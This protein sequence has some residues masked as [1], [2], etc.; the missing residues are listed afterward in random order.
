[1]ESDL[2]GADLTEALL[3]GAKLTAANLAGANLTGAD[4]A[5]AAR[6]CRTRMPDES[7]CDRDCDPEEFD[8]ACSWLLTSQG[9]EH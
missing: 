2:I 3:R 5:E 7:M 6:V 9:E 1:M 4:L 8:Q